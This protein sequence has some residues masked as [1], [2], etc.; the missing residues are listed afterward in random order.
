MKIDIRNLLEGRPEYEAL[1]DGN[2]EPKKDGNYEPK[3]DGNY[4]PKKEESLVSEEEIRKETEFVRRIIDSVPFPVPA[5][6]R[7]VLP[8]GQIVSEGRTDIGAEVATDFPPAQRFRQASRNYR[9]FE[10][11]VPMPVRE[12]YSSNPLDQAPKNTSFD[13]APEFRVGDGKPSTSDVYR[14]PVQGA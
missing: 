4:E 14:D 2:Y 12:F 6:A 13:T 5:R 3:K 1:K 11:I 10:W 7:V 9:N 8:R